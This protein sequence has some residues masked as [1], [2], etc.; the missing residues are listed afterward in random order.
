[1]LYKGEAAVEMNKVHE[2]TK[3]THRKDTRKKMSSYV[4]GVPSGPR[5]KE[6]VGVSKKPVSW[7]STFVTMVLQEDG[8]RSDVTFL[9]QT[10][11]TP[12]CLL[13]SP[14]CLP[15]QRRPRC[16]FR[17]HGHDDEKEKM[18]WKDNQGTQTGCCFPLTT[19]MTAMIVCFNNV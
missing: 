15:A 6:N 14:V 19:G 1:M 5:R 13:M 2:N 8:R 18:F 4:S 17:P 9:V 11:W 3:E 10:F 7:T 12:P 16:A